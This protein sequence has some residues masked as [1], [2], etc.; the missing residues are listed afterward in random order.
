MNQKPQNTSGVPEEITDVPKELASEVS[1]EEEGALKEANGG[2][3]PRPSPARMTRAWD[4][5]C[6]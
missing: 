4:Y 5:W 2:V 3:V 1:K 6:S